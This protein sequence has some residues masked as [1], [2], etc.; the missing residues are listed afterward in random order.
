MLNNHKQIFTLF[1]VRFAANT[2]FEYLLSCSV[3]FSRLL[4]GDSEA[5]LYHEIFAVS[6]SSFNTLRYLEAAVVLHE[7]LSDKFYIKVVAR[8]LTYINVVISTKR[9]LTF[10]SIRFFEL[11]FSLIPS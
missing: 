5:L 9:S 8:I 3:P 6:A 2:S 7:D 10:V 4:D 11:C 1:F